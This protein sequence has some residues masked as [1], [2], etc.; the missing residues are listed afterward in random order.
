MHKKVKLILPA[1]AAPPASSGQE[2]AKIPQ[3]PTPTQS[4]L[5]TEVF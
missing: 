2:E 4:S 3:A 1:Q 5:L